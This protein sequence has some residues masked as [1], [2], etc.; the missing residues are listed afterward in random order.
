[1]RWLLL[2]LLLLTL[3][4]QY[5]LWWAEGGRL[6]MRRLAQQAEDYER[7]NTRLKARNAQLAQQIL[8]LKSG[9]IVLEQRAREELGLTAE[10]EIYY[11][12]VEPDADDNG[13]ALGKIEKAE[14]AE[15]A[16]KADKPETGAPEA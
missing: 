3:G 9:Q 1:M 4:L 2:G 13:G 12:F 6:E 16:E 8:D 14:I 15:S 5:R 11:Q 7:E 10:D